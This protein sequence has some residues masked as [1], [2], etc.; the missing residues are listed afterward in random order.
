MNTIITNLKYIEINVENIF[1]SVLL[2]PYFVLVLLA[3]NEIIA[4]LRNNNVEIF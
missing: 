4:I 3:N 2:F 1:E